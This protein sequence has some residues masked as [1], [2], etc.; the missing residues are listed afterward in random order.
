[1]HPLLTSFP[2]MPLC[3]SQRLYRRWQWKVKY[4]DETTELVDEAGVVSLIEAMVELRRQELTDKYQ[5]EQSPTLMRPLREA[6]KPLETY[7]SLLDSLLTQV[8]DLWYEDEMALL[9]Y[10][11]S[12]Y[13]RNFMKIVSAPPNSELY[14]RCNAQLSAILIRVAPGESERV[15]SEC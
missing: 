5:Q 1:M 3:L 11:L 14:K 6:E 12:H 13:I 8:D 9:G 4:E 15:Q 2:H 7:S 10:D